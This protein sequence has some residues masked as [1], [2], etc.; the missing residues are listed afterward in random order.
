MVLLIEDK[1][2]KPEHLSQKAKSFTGGK[3]IEDP[4]STKNLTL[5]EESKAANQ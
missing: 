5:F 2:C 4:A 1:V 3:V